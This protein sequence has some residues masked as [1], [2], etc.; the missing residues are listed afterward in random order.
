MNS[1]PLLEIS[2]EL[3]CVMGYG[4]TTHIGGISLIAVVDFA[5]FDAG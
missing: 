3:P 4:R 2:Y 1:L 5:A